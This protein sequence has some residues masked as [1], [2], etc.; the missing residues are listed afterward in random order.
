M[1]AVAD[2]T[3]LEVEALGGAPGVYSARFAGEHATYADNVAKLLA[4]LARVGAERPDEPMARFR[5]VAM[6][7]YPDGTRCL[8]R[9]RGDRRDRPG[10][11]R[12]VGIRL[13][14]GVRARGLPGADLCPDERRGEAPDLPSG[15]RLPGARRPAWDE[16]RSPPERRYQRLAS[17]ACPRRRDSGERQFAGPVGGWPRTASGTHRSRPRAPS[18]PPRSPAATRGGSPVRRRFR[19]HPGGRVDRHL[20]TGAPPTSGYG[21]P[22]GLPATG[23]HRHRAAMGIRR[24]TATCRCRRPTA[25]PWRRWSARS[26][27]GSTGS[28]RCW[29]SCSG[30][31]P[32]PR[33]SDPGD[34]QRGEGLA[35]AGI[36]IGF[37]SLVISAVVITIIVV[38]G[39]WHCHDT[40]NCTFNTTVNTGD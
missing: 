11:D 18:P 3:G 24:A 39:R 30:S 6:V 23:R 20:A 21:P 15:P 27:S 7:A 28:A 38:V 1:P 25:W 2:D 17:G 13:R 35:L 26:S 32:D 40:G 16:V 12:R 14:P 8:G 10:G 33:S 29:P 34:T 4:E 19:W 9:R 22:P 36:I 31:S 5:S 37:A